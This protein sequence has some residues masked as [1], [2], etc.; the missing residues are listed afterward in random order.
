MTPRWSDDIQVKKYSL[1][2]LARMVREKDRSYEY[3]GFCLT[4]PPTQ[5]YRGAPQ[6]GKG[7]WHLRGAENTVNVKRKGSSQGLLHGTG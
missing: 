6:P 5:R 1:I 7:I 2:D 3:H 4:R